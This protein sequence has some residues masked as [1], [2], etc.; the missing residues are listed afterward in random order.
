[1]D[2]PSPAK[3]Q[4]VG[5]LSPSKKAVFERAPAPVQASTS[6]RRTSAVRRPSGYFAQRKSLG[7]GTLTTAASLPSL[8]GSDRRTAP[9]LRPRAS[10]GA[11]PSE[12]SQ[13]LYPDLSH[14]E[15]PVPSPTRAPAELY[16]DVSHIVETPPTLAGPLREQSLVTVPPRSTT[17]P[18]DK[19]ST[20]S[21]KEVFDQNVVVLNPATESSS[22]ASVKAAQRA[23]SP[24]SRGKESSPVPS[25]TQAPPR[26]VP[27]SPV[28]EKAP[29]TAPAPKRVSPSQTSSQVPSTN[30]VQ[31]APD[32]SVE[33]DDE[34]DME[35]TEQWRE[36][37]DQP[38]EMYDGE[39]VS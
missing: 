13:S 25:S 8:G 32:E 20:L 36:D 23:A 6:N 5:K 39:E 15:E 17:P 22:S 3:K 21:E 27:P 24:I 2:L 28:H 33:H 10:M 34:D 16:P 38:D 35:F 30:T 14:I 4:A 18:H 37:L 11:V 9:A 29:V 26:L 19:G 1:M 31:T 12:D 7:G